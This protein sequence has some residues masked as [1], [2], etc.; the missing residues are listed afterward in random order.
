MTNPGG[1]SQKGFNLHIVTP[2]G[3]PQ[4][5]TIRPGSGLPSTWAPS[6]HSKGQP[7]PKGKGK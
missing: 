5:R 6:K 3:R 1:R 4:D 7:K 2:R